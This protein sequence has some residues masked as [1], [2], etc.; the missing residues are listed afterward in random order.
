M[1]KKLATAIAAAERDFAQLA[2]EA[3]YLRIR[4]LEAKNDVAAIACLA[5]GARVELN[6]ARRT[7]GEGYLRLMNSGISHRAFLSFVRSLP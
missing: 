4:A 1:S 7:I 3:E 5:D 2:T 6:S